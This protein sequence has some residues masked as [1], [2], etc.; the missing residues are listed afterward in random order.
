[1]HENERITV[2]GVDYVESVSLSGSWWHSGRGFERATD[3]CPRGYRIVSVDGVTITHRYHSSC[4][5]QVDRQGE[6]MRL[7]D[8]VPAKRSA[9]FTF[10]CYDAP[11][12]STAEARLD[13]GPWRPM[14]QFKYKSSAIDKPHNFRLVADTTLLRPGRHTIEARV[15]W[16]DGTVV[17]EKKTFVRAE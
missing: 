16:P 10:N 14:T 9:G 17:I 12:G 13:D 2:G 6:F 7:G 3:G 1:M 4:E 8:R 11:N 5:S 15:T